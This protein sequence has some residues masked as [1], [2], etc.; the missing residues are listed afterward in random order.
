MIPFLLIFP[1]PRRKLSPAI[2]P[3]PVMQV[4]EDGDNFIPF[5]KCSRVVSRSPPPS[6]PSQDLRMMPQRYG[7]IFWENLSQRPSSIW[8]EEQYIPPMLRAIGCSHAG[9]FTPEGLPPP[10][11]LC[12]RK[13]RKPRLAGVQQG[14]GGTPARVK[15]VTYH[16]EDLRRRQG[17]IDELKKAQWSSSGATSEPLVFGEEGPGFLDTTEYPDLEEERAACLREEDH[18]LTPGR[19]QLLWSPWSP[20]G[21]ESSCL[22]R[23]Q[24]FLASYGTV[25]ASRRQLYGPW[26]MEFESEE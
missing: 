25:T 19:A 3:S 1:K 21:Q 12:R 16:L 7:D 10:E 26:G 6:L 18:F 23:G 4:P 14:P 2:Q 9:L 13:R 11:M 5:A 24:S 15:A 17:I 8:M 20:L 22:S